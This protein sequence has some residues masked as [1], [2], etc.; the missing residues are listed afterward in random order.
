MCFSAAKEKRAFMGMK[1]VEEVAKTAA[2]AKEA[3]A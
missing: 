2:A 3:K 1:K